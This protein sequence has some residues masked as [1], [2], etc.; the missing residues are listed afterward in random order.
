MTKHRYPTHRNCTY[1][2]P[3]KSYPEGR[4]KWMRERTHGCW[5]SAWKLNDGQWRI[6]RL[7]RWCKPK[8]GELRS[9]EREPPN[10]VLGDTAADK[11][12]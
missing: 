4:E 8:P 3:G 9:T 10:S 12:L 6:W 5:C 1:I 2:L 7:G 11:T